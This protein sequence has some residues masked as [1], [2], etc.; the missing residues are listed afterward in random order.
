[1]QPI[2]SDRPE[3]LKDEQFISPWRSSDMEG[4]NRPIFFSFVMGQTRHKL[5]L[6]LLRG[7]T[8]RKSCSAK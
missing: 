5:Q 4:A 8:K 1:M 3:V 6:L 2:I 7:N